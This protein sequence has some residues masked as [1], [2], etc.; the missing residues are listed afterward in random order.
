VLRAALT[1]A[2]RLLAVTTPDP[3]ALADTYALIKILSLEAP[4]LPVDLL[5]NRVGSE[6]EAR[7]AHRRLEDATGRFLGRPLDCLGAVPEDGT[8]MRAVRE[9]RSLTDLDARVAPLA[10]RLLEVLETV[11]TDGRYT[12]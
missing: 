12:S 8:V 3:A 6:D 1:R 2:T 4:G 9:S 7:A 11:T 5:V 10:E